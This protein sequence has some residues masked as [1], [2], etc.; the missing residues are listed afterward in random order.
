M[1]LALLR[2]HTRTSCGRKA[3]VVPAAPMDPKTFMTTGEKRLKECILSI[4]PKE[5]GC[6]GKANEDDQPAK[7]GL[8]DHPGEAG[9]RVAA[10]GA[11]DNGQQTVTPDHLAIDHKEDE[12]NSV[13]RSRLPGRRHEYI[14][15]AHRRA[16]PG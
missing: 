8:R 6:H 11:G 15:G 4:A 7:N 10:D 16:Q 3:V 14:A 2:R 9:R 1:S 13:C 5:P 12:G